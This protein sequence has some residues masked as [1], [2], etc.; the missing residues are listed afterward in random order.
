MYFITS[1]SNPAH[2]DPSHKTHELYLVFRLLVALNYMMLA[3][4]CESSSS[5]EK[6]DKFCGGSPTGSLLSQL[7]RLLQLGVDS[8]CTIPTYQ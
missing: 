5:D 2:I 7:Q 8:T 4:V 6:F 3:I 1:V